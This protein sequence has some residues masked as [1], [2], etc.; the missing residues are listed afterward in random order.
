MGCPTPMGLG[1]KLMCE[2]VSSVTSGVTPDGNGRE[3]PS[4]KFV[5]ASTVVPISAPETMNR[6]RTAVI[7]AFA[8]ILD[9]CNFSF[10]FQFMAKL[11]KSSAET[12]YL[13]Q[14]VLRLSQNENT[15]VPTA[16]LH[17]QQGGTG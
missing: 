7:V 11:G 16:S 8:E 5:C 12:K 17:K 6:I 10:S 9:K 14:T 15:R 2:I 1:L 3:P 13:P 4:R